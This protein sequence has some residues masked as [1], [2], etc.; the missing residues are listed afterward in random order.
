MQTPYRNSPQNK[1]GS[2]P[3]CCQRISARFATSEDLRRRDA[4]AAKAG[5]L[6]EPQFLIEMNRLLGQAGIFRT[7]APKKGGGD[8][9]GTMGGVLLRGVRLGTSRIFLV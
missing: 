9:M 1:K 8:E 4:R 2:S 6:R 3:E 7:V 5:G